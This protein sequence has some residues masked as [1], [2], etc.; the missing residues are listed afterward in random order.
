MNQR[1]VG[2]LTRPPVPHSGILENTP[3]RKAVTIIYGEESIPVVIVQVKSSKEDQVLVLCRKNEKKD[4]YCLME[5]SAFTSVISFDGELSIFTPKMDVKPKK[6][7]LSDFKEGTLYG[8]FAVMHDD[9]TFDPKYVFAVYGD[10]IIDLNGSIHQKRE[11]ILEVIEVVP[12]LKI[13]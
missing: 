8:L 6:M 13:E 5:V 12:Y 2:F 7:Q 4:S 11:Q 3:A 9:C 10:K 1:Y